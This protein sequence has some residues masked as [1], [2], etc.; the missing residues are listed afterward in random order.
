MHTVIMTGAEQQ[1]QMINEINKAVRRCKIG[2][3]RP[4]AR[5]VPDQIKDMF[6]AVMFPSM[7]TPFPAQSMPKCGCKVGAACG[8]VACPHR[9]IATC[10]T[11]IPPI[12]PAHGTMM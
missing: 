9:L 8:N 12:V 7:G 10:N 4:K 6:R 2:R 3:V 5:P 11:S 1:R